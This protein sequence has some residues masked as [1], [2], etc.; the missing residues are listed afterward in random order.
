LRHYSCLTSCCL[1]LLTALLL[2]SA[3]PAEQLAETLTLEDC[4]RLALKRNPNLKAAA[5]EVDSSRASLTAQRARWWPTLSAEWAV[6][7]Q[8]SLTRST[9]RD[10]SLVLNQTFYQSGLRESIQAAD[11]RLVGSRYSRDDQERRLLVQV[12]TAFYGVL[13]SLEMA[14]VARAGVEAARQN[15]ELVNARVETGTAAEVDRLPVEL[16]LAEAEL[17]AMRA[18]NATWQAMA[19]LRALLA[20]DQGPPPTLSGSLGPVPETGP[21]SSWVA[22]ARE[23]RPDLAAQR[24]SIRTADLALKEARIAA[25]LSVQASGQA[26]Y[27]RHTG[28]TDETWSL[29]VGASYPLGDKSV[30]AEVAA[31]EARREIA[32][33]RLADLELSITRD[34]EQNWYG[35]QD[36]TGRIGAAR[37]AVEAAQS[38]LE[39]ARQRYA[40]GVAIVV[41][42]T[43]AELSLR[44]VRANLIQARY[45]QNVAYYQLLAAAGQPLLTEPGS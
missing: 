31:A 29:M 12:A 45:D 33:Q 17:E 20:L 35:L 32:H 27:G 37:I 19:E 2:V 4:F 11:A 22:E 38:N 21:L 1:C 30:K 42:V 28:T 15:L 25:G 16:T 5:L 8:Q 10:L 6:R 7:E 14:E 18:M 44:R 26:D 23:Q 41:E 36:A 13:G 39:A 43:D 24:V 34:V 3:A 40:E 9:S